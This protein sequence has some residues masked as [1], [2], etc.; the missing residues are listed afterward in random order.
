[1]NQRPPGLN[2]TKAITGFLQWWDLIP[3]HCFE[4][5]ALNTRRG[6]SHAVARKLNLSYDPLQ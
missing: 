4:C 3:D 1:M 6:G 5:R 2:V